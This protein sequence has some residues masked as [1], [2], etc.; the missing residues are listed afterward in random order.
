MIVAFPLFLA[1]S[2]PSRIA[3]KILVLLTPAAVAASSGVRA[4]RG[5]AR[6]VPPG[7]IASIMHYLAFRGIEPDAVA[8]TLIF[9]GAKA[10]SNSKSETSAPPI[11]A[12]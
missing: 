5:M 2:V 8:L 11:V 3:S 10:D 9:P 7:C 4:S 12:G 1:V 6:P